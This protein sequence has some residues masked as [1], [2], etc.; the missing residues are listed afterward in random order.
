MKTLDEQIKKKI[1]D[2]LCDDSRIDAAGIVIKVNNGIVEMIGCVASKNEKD[3]AEKVAR[4]YGKVA[5]VKNFIAVGPD[6]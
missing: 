1:V 2:A 5:Q 3:F 6:E 4:E